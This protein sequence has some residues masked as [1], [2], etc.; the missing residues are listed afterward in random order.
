[1]SEIIF[2]RKLTIMIV[3]VTISLFLVEASANEPYVTDKPKG[4]N[5]LYKENATL[6]PESK[7]SK[8]DQDIADTLPASQIDNFTRAYTKEYLDEQPMVFVVR[9]EDVPQK[10]T[11]KEKRYAV[12][13]RNQRKKSGGLVDWNDPYLQP[14]APLSFD[15]ENAKYD[16]MTEE[17]K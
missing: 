15:M 16:C 3:R 11:K 13:E 2:S 5:N 7:T 10:L 17:S 4:A 8:F 14:E 12:Y 6:L 1:M 9:C